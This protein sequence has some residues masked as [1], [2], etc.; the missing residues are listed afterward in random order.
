[1]KLHIVANTAAELNALLKNPV[2]TAAEEVTSQIG[3][4]EITKLD[5]NRVILT[6][7]SIP[8]N[9]LAGRKLYQIR[10]NL[11]YQDAGVAKEEREFLVKDGDEADW[12]NAHGSVQRYEVKSIGIDL[13]SRR[14]AKLKAEFP[15]MDD[16]RKS[17]VLAQLLGISEE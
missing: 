13:E 16:E 5:S 1:M 3:M 9:L 14:L 7:M 15:E 12:A 17:E 10:L 4:K 11:N 2:A 8:T 6:S